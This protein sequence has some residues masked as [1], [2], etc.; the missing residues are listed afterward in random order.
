LRGLQM[1]LLELTYEDAWG[2]HL[3]QVREELHHEALQF[4]KEQRIRSLLQGSWF[5]LDSHSKSESGPVQKSTATYQ[6][7]QLSHN[8]RYLHF[9]QFDLMGDRPPELDTLPEKSECP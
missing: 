1:E 2:Q 3:R 7:A 6:Y 9:G 5:A 8:R 4:V